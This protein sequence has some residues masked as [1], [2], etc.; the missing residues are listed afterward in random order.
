MENTIN[1]WNN[2]LY[3]TRFSIYHCILR[4]LFGRSLRL[5]SL[6]LCALV[7]SNKVVKSCVAHTTITIWCMWFVFSPILMNILIPNFLY[8]LKIESLI[9]FA[10]K[11]TNYLYYINS[12]SHDLASYLTFVNHLHPYCKYVTT[13]IMPF[14]NL[15]ELIYN[16]TLNTFVLIKTKKEVANM[17]MVNL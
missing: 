15:K 9:Y 4:R 2:L 16:P 6:F 14:K 5:I 3:Q 17:H 7:V 13:T 1:V 11:L 12:C 8:N 10:T